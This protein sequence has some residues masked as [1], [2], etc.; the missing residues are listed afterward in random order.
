MVQLAFPIPDDGRSGGRSAY[1]TVAEAA[2]ELRCHERTIVAPSTGERCEPAVSAAPTRRAGRGG[3]AARTSTRGCTRSRRE[4]LDA[5]LYAEPPEAAPCRVALG[6]SRPSSCGVGVWPTGLV[7][8]ADRPLLGRARGPAAPVLRDDGRSRLRAG[9]P[10][11]GPESPRADRRPG[12]V[13]DLGRL[14]AYLPRRRVLTATGGA[15]RQLRGRLAARG[16]AASRRPAAARDHAARDLDVAGRDAEGRQG[17]G[18]DPHVHDVG[19]GGVHAGAGVGRGIDQPGGLGAQAASRASARNRRHGPQL[20]RA[21][22]RLD[23]RPR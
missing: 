1:V 7:G 17:T 8:D 9:A 3:S 14:L 15:D 10:R 5:W 13:H 4:D 16:R 18:S 2:E 20:G 6:G 23:A 22:L 11:A 12:R 19:P 21:R